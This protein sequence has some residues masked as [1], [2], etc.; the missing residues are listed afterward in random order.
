MKRKPDMMVAVIALFFVG[1]VVSGFSSEFSN[2]KN[3]GVDGNIGQRHSLSVEY[4]ASR[5]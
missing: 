4:A 2:S 5:G 3:V 1:L